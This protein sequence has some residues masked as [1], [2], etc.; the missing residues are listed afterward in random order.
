METHARF[1]L[2]GLFSLAVTVGLIVFVLW[3]GK[4][5]LDRDY[6]NYEIRFRESVTGL[7]VGGIV[8][9]Q[10]VQVGEVRKL[11]LDP[12]DPRV[13]RAIVRVAA[14]TPVKTD[15]Q[16]QLSYTGLTGV[17]VV[18][19]LGGSPEARLLRETDDSTAPAIDAVPSS[20]S[21]LM[22]GGSGAMQSAEQALTR[23]GTMLDD[24]N[25]E[26]VSNLLANLET[27]S[28]S[29][30]GD[31]PEFRAALA[32]ARA[33]ERR[34]DTAVQ[35]A[36]SLLTEMQRGLGAT[37]D[38]ADDSV[39]HELRA[40]IADIGAAAAAFERFSTSGERTVSGLDAAARAELVSTLQALQQA[41]ENLSRIT[42]R[43]DQAPVDYLR[44]AQ[45][46]PVYT[47]E[48]ETR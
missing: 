32:D 3:L 39:F 47:P 18:E 13:V 26:R 21:Q 40:T 17:A 2:V 34:L 19:L 48:R 27:I 1:F 45:A 9:Y 33:L 16:A 12:N 23:I 46:L 29:V 30:A 8:Q 36:D 37:S 28:A 43:F 31:Y 38:D 20:L 10:G 41:S 14:T 22:S 7:S 5:Q 4:L 35:R 11:S 44:G 6:Q 24:R 25:L 42:L 15:T